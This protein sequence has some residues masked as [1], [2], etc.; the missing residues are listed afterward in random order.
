MSGLN[1]INHPYNT[2]AATDTHTL[3]CVWNC[4]VHFSEV[5]YSGPS[6]S[7]LLFLSCSLPWLH[8]Q[9]TPS[10][11]EFPVHPACGCF[12]PS[13]QLCSLGCSLKRSLLCNN[14]PLN[15]A[16]NPDGS[17]NNRHPL[18]PLLSTGSITSTNSSSSRLLLLYLAHLLGG[19]HV[20]REAGCGRGVI[21]EQCYQ[22]L[23]CSITARVAL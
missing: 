18:L 9:Q 12:S 11:P 2:G 7:S 3:S 15:L 22:Q 20:W 4:P 6:S 14:T 5:S 21:Y 10:C 19:A 1:N 23:Q 16:L 8:P 13:H 17:T